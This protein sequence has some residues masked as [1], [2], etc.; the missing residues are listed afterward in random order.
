MK[1]GAGC[2]PR[3]AAGPLAALPRPA[4]GPLLIGTATLLDARGRLVKR[5]PLRLEAGSDLAAIAKLGGRLDALLGRRADVT[6]IVPGPRER[7]FRSGLLLGELVGV[8]L[9]HSTDFVFVTT[10]PPSPMPVKRA[11]HRAR[12]IARLRGPRVLVE[13]RWLDL[14]RPAMPAGV[15][16]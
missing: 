5:L 7:S 2:G 13:L 1:S 11:V 3:L 6:L 10:R 16:S 14:Q 12:P 8:L 4:R 9:A 15:R